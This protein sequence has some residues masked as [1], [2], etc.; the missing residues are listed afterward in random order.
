MTLQPLC[1][2]NSPCVKHY[3]RKALT[4]TTGYRFLC[5]CAEGHICPTNRAEGEVH[6]ADGE[7]TE[8]PYLNGYCK[9]IQSHLKKEYADKLSNKI[10]KSWSG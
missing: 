8:G 3:L 4:K 7:D 2:E 1:T 9:K 10:N 5:T 6:T